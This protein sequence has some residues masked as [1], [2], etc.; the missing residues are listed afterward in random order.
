[1]TLLFLIFGLIIGIILFSDGKTDKKTHCKLH[2]WVY[3]NEG[4]PEEYMSCSVCKARPG[5]G[6][7]EGIEL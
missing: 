7:D 2:K 6:I 4:T 1:M 5:I 3:N